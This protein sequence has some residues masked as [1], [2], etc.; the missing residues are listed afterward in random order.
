MIEADDDDLKE[1]E[2]QRVS[3]I[4]R[5]VVLNRRKASEKA[6]SSSFGLSRFKKMPSPPPPHAPP[7]P[8][9]PTPPPPPPP[10]APLHTLPPRATRPQS[11]NQNRLREAGGKIK[12]K[13]INTS[14]RLPGRK[15]SSSSSSA[16]SSSSP[17]T[18]SMKASASA[19]EIPPRSASFSAYLREKVSNRNQNQPQNDILNVNELNLF[20]ISNSSVS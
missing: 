11:S 13:L 7:P 8:P 12:S 5:A 1:A 6:A 14:F 4:P 9:T 16:S 17:P 2:K 18:T 19:S 15:A 10:A 3:L 20:R